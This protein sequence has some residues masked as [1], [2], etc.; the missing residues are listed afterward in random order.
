MDTVRLLL[1]NGVTP[2]AAGK[3]GSTALHVAA[4]D[5]WTEGMDVLLAAGAD[6]D[7][8]DDRGMTP[9]WAA[10]GAAGPVER[11]NGTRKMLQAG[12]DAN[13]PGPEGKNLLVE[14]ASRRLDRE[15]AELVHYGAEVNATDGNGR[16]AVGVAGRARDYAL[17]SS[18]LSRGADGTSL[19]PVALERNDLELARVLF[20]H[21][22]RP[23]LASADDGAVAACVRLGQGE[24]ARLCLEAGA[25]PDGRGREGQRPLHMAVAMRD[26][27][28]VRVLLEGGANPD[29]HFARPVAKSFLDLTEKESMR[30]FLRH[31]RRITPLMMAANNGDLEIISNLIN[32]GAKKY[33]YSGRYRLYPVNFASRRGDIKA[34]QVMLGQ[35]PDKEKMHAVLDLSE[36]RVRLYNAGGKV[37]F[38]SH[39]S[40]GKSGYRT[41]KGVYVITDKHRSHSSTIYGS[42]MPYFQRLSCGSFGFHAGNCPGY[43][44]SHGCIRMPHSAARKMFRVTPVGTRV[45]IQR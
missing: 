4:G 27:G 33:V 11:W 25:D 38:S 42:S 24:M 5:G 9:L 3:D 30:W 23:V 21:G 41:P 32:H 40:T 36:Q 2:D 6:P 17:V 44:A 34:M 31:D 12:A 14:A 45:V 18:L 29:L 7:A 28:M 19:L 26:A 16:T 8:R 20:S 10:V 35:D 15:A 39:V 1:N 13:S 43:P 22:V 37:I